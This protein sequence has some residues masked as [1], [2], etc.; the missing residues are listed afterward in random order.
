ME[1]SKKTLKGDL[2]LAS[3]EAIEN[4]RDKLLNAKKI[5]GNLTIGIERPEKW[6][7]PIVD[8]IAF[9]NITHITGDLI[10]K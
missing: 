6:K 10:I 4:L 2:V 3:Q 8:L 5:E 9:R 1:T 7:S